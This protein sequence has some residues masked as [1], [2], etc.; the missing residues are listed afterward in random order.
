MVIIVVLE[1]KYVF[2]HAFMA[3]L[4]LQNHHGFHKLTYSDWRMDENL[5]VHEIN[6]VLNEYEIYFKRE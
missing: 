6:F 2:K 5:I 1:I 3:S 4:D